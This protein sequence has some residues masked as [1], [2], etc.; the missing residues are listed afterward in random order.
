MFNRLFDRFPKRVE[1]V[2]VFPSA[3][4]DPPSPLIG[5]SELRGGHLNKWLFGPRIEEPI[6]AD[7]YYWPDITVSGIGHLWGPDGLVTNLIPGYWRDEI[8]SGRVR[9]EADRSLPVRDI[10]PECICALGWGLNVYGHFV[11]EMLPRLLLA[12]RVSKRASV[13]LPTTAPQ[14]MKDRIADIGFH[15]VE[16]FNPA[17]EQVRLL[18]GIVP[19]YLYKSQGLHPAA[20]DLLDALPFPPVGRTNEAVY[21]TRANFSSG[22]ATSRNCINERELEAI[23]ADLGY[24]VVAPETMSWPEQIA[25]FR[26]ASIVT[27]LYGSALHSA[28]FSDRGLSVGVVGRVNLAQSHIAALRS[29]PIGYLLE[30]FALSRSYAVP[31]DSFTAFLAA[32]RAA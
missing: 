15:K 8:S 18:R 29:Q 21:V 3:P 4:P 14:W 20:R 10:E 13:L 9:P 5:P 28:V 17:A 19:T 12:R 32:L 6:A 16:M 22:R 31:V 7:C 25:L 23:A 1:R 26:R 11:I 27:G 24:Q 30:G 2:S